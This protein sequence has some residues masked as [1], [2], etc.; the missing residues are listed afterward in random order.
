[1]IQPPYQLQLIKELIPSISRVAFIWNP[2][3]ASNAIILKEL[4]VA[5]PVL[6]LQLIARRSSQ[7]KRS[8]R[9]ICNDY[10]GAGRSGLDHHDPLHQHNITAIIEFLNRNRLPGIFQI[11]ENVVACG[12]CPTAQVFPT[13]SGTARSTCTRYCKVRGRKTCRCSSPNGSNWSSI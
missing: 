11:R 8:R 13:C 9:R 1:M 2:D 4:R 3:N 7:F 10:G 6:G 5:A 12:L